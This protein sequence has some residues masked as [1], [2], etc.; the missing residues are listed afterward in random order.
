M[1]GVTT[2][3]LTCS[4]MTRRDTGWSSATASC[5]PAGNTTLAW[6][7]RTARNAPSSSVRRPRMTVD[8]RFPRDVRETVDED[9][10]GTRS[11]IITGPVSDWATDFSHLEPEWSAD[12]YPIQDQLRERCPIAHT[13]RFGGGW[14]PTRYEDVAASAYGTERFGSR[15]I[16]TGNFRPPPEIAPVGGSPPISSDPPFHHDARKLLLPAFTRSAVSRQEPATRAFCHSLI[17][18]F[19]G[20]DVV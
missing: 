17:D 5:R 11:E 10:I 13:D 19:D 8:E 4:A 7:W 15:S 9:P 16:T 2:G 1:V 14:L 3:R 18:S 6:R 20:Q 12:P